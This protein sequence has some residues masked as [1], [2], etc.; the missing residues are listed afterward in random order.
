MR[1]AWEE[2]Q[3]V[4][5]LLALSSSNILKHN[6]QLVR[7]TGHNSVSVMMKILP[8]KRNFFPDITAHMYV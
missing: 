5:P 7:V 8:K 3:K 2:R 4:M 6:K 1:V